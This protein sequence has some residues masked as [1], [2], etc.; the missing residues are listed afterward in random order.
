MHA[1][2][3]NDQLEL[4]KQYVERF[5]KL[6]GTKTGQEITDREALAHFESLIELVR[7]VYQEI[8]PNKE[9]EFD[10]CLKHCTCA[11]RDST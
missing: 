5:Q 4:K 3:S 11:D 1:K 6:H 8:P 10:I 2:E 7:A 9:N